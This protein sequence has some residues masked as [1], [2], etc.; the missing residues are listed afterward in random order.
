M[1]D[2]SL[3]DLTFGSAS[4]LNADHDRGL[5]CASIAIDDR[6]QQ[7]IVTRGPIGMI[8]GNAL[9]GVAIAEVPKVLDDINTRR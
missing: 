3:D 5:S 6:Q 1:L 2:G 4:G 9:A 7:S 8:D